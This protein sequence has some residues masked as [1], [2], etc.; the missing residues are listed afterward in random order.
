MSSIAKINL[1]SRI[2]HQLITTHLYDTTQ[3]V[4]DNLDNK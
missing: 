2:T 4:Y 1:V 3:H